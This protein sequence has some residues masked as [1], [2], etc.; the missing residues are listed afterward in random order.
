MT[1]IA[2]CVILV[3]SGLNFAVSSGTEN[4]DDLLEKNE[5]VVTDEYETEPYEEPYML[6]FSSI[7][8]ATSFA[9][10][11][12]TLE[13]P[14]MIYNVHDLQN[15]SG[16]LSA[17]YA[18][19][20]DIEAS[21]TREWN[22]NGTGYEGFVPIGDSDY[23]FTG[24]F[25]GRNQTIIGLYIN[26]SYIYFA[27]VSLFGFVDDGS[28]VR[29]VGM[30]DVDI[31]G[32]SNRY[33]GG[34]VGENRG[35]VYNSYATGDVIGYWG[36]G[37]LVGRN[38]GKI[39][40][41]YAS[42]E[43]RGNIAVG[44]LVGHNWGGTAENS[45]ASVNVTIRKS[46][47]Y[48]NSNM[49]G[50]VGLNN[51]A[52]SNSYSEGNVYA[53][54]SSDGL[55]HTSVGG[56]V[57]SN[58]GAVS[59]SYYNIDTVLINNAH[60]VTLGG[61]YNEQY[62]DWIA[63]DL[64]LD[65]SD[66]SDT[67]VPTGDS[68]VISEI[69]G[70]KDLL[71]FSGDGYTF[72]LG[73]NID[74]SS[75]P[76][77]YIPSF[78]GIFDGNN[79]TISHLNINQPFSQNVGLFGYLFTGSQVVNVGLVDI[80]VTGYWIVGGLVGFNY[81]GAI[82]N[83]YTIGEVNGYSNIGGLVGLNRDGSVYNSY[84]T[85]K[86]GSIE[87]NYAGFEPRYAGGLVG[88][89]RDGTISTSHS[90][91]DIN[92]LGYFI[93]GGLVGYNRGGLI[94]DSYTTGNVSGGDVVGGIVGENI[95]TVSNT[96]AT[97][98]VSGGSYV[99]GLMGWNWGTVS[100]SYST[101]AVSG[102]SYVGG[103][104]GRNEGGTV[105]YSYATGTVCSEWGE[106]GGLVGVNSGR[107]YS[108]Y[109]TGNVSGNFGVGGLVGFMGGSNS[110]IANSYSTCNVR[111]KGLAGG[112]I[113]SNGID[114][115]MPIPGGTVTDSYSKGDITRIM[116]SSNSRL[117]GFLGFNYR[118][119]IINCYSTGSVQYEDASDPTDKGFAGPVD[120]GGDYEMTGNFWDVETSGQ[121][122]TA[123]NATGKTTAEMMDID[124]YANAGWNIVSVDDANDRNMFYLWNIVDYETYPFLSW[125][126]FTLKIFTSGNGTV[127]IEPQ[128]HTYPYGMEVIV[129]A[130]SDVGWYFSHW[131]GDV[132]DGQEADEEITIVMDGGKTLTA[133][134]A[135][136]YHDLNLTLEGEGTT[137]PEEGNHS[138]LY[139]SDVNITAIPDEGWYFSHWSGDV[140][141]GQ[142]TNENITIVMDSDKNITAH[143][144]QIYHNLT[145]SIIGEGTTDPP[146]GNHTYTYG[147][148]VNI[149][150]TSAAGWRFSHWTGDVPEGNETNENITV[151][152]DR[153][154]NITAHFQEL[155][156]IPENLSLTVTP[157]EGETPLEVT[158]T[159]GAN[160]SGLLEGSIDVVV[161]DEVVYTLVIPAEGTAEHTFDHTFES[162]GTF[163][164]VFGEL[165]KNV[166]VREVEEEVEPE[167][168][169][170]P[171]WGLLLIA[172]VVIALAAVLFMMKRKPREEEAIQDEEESSPD[173]EEMLT[174]QDEEQSSQEDEPLS[175]DVDY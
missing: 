159:V 1:C 63:N 79:H 136:I 17:H 175:E 10:G 75:S 43:V 113:G 94:T 138:Y 114:G 96:Y 147:T 110:L 166:V 108:S 117:G 59:N 72:I 78:K 167:D 42:G 11:S 21:E 139:G 123:G 68:Y 171:L 58:G 70:F 80:N 13:D 67:L 121:I 29:N 57:G 77:H 81:F 150:A 154:I 160:N 102:G 66:Y 132:P 51:G 122:S 62:N 47:G 145:V 140:P 149:T 134:F 24:T 173:E 103:L 153:D 84:T 126:G 130:L 170:F 152:M 53:G 12:G 16:D 32:H 50:L 164:I 3:F 36:I 60:H 44:G 156:F 124:T 118:G 6:E 86:I 26:R 143:F 91:C 129:T 146:T 101:G 52:V 27:Y 71:G 155:L 25:D 137:V 7:D 116:D 74:L 135:Q 119:K 172:A 88:Y 2:L 148:S 163:E 111:G 109:A 55:P 112:L 95:G 127:D 85:G 15:M 82:D 38:F 158:I 125:E 35:N 106:V 76:G 9:R 169:G 22:W 87:V 73:S 30:V 141:G 120:T 100:N 39:A 41:S 48:I 89:N 46:L 144:E 107:V 19:A 33:V 56:L 18:L 23:T 90:S 99:G 65:I 162:A 69:Q 8:V 37:G 83:S 104:V 45:Y 157:L 49:G 133:H 115:D 161:D 131:T 93:S 40:N 98:T 28:E 92:V 31:N 151:L 34:L 105:S 54:E 4:I 97:G 168:A 14:Y 128:R 64:Y 174:E 142:E 5:S 61:L 20:N 165:S